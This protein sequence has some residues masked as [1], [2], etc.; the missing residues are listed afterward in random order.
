[1]WILG[2]DRG[3]LGIVFE[4]YEIH[5]EE[6]AVVGDCIIEEFGARTDTFTRMMYIYIHRSK[7]G[8]FILLFYHVS[9][10]HTH[11]QLVMLHDLILHLDKLI[12]IP[13][14]SE[15]AS[16]Q[17]QPSLLRKPDQ[18]ATTEARIIV[19]LR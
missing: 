8:C 19:Q 15:V 13:I 4:G 9:Q 12:H 18:K 14:G 16:T 1:M 17:P 11:F 6:K 5:I 3:L 2:R 10:H 7:G